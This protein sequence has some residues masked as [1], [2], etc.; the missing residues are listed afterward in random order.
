MTNNVFSKPTETFKHALE[1]PSLLKAILIVLISTIPFAGT[2][3]F[4]SNDIIISSLLV[5]GF[6]L[7]WI[8][9]SLI[10]WIF[11]FMFTTKKRVHVKSDFFGV[12]SAT[13]KLWLFFLLIGI[14]TL[15]GIIGELIMPLIGIIIIVLF[16]LIIIYSF[17]LMQIIIDG[18][19]GRTLVTWIIAMILYG[20][21]NSLVFSIIT[22][23]L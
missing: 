15:I 14:L 2:V 22:I 19:P 16:A 7:N 21:L 20:L 6:F 5:L 12:L 13:S 10:F 4:I 23:L 11:S 18:T 3:F 9:F 1:E 17:I 8:V